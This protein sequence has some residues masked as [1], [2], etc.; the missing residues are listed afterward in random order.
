MT[1]TH[2]ASDSGEQVFCP[3]AFVQGGQPLARGQGVLFTQTMDH[4][5]RH[6]VKNVKPARA[7]GLKASASVKMAH[8]VGALSGS[9][10]AS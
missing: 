4:R 3:L 10:A 1:T 7:D 5:D 8:R 2:A 6:L 9:V